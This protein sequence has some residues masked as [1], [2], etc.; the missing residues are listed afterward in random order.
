MLGWIA[1]AAALVAIVVA[2]VNL[3][4]IRKTD[5]FVASFHQNLAATLHSMQ[6]A[7]SSLALISPA[8]LAGASIPAQYTCDLAGQAG[9]VASV[10]P[11]SPPFTVSGVPSEAK[12]LAL[13]MDDPDVPKALRPTGVFDHWVLF[14]I[15]PTVTDIAEGES[16]GVAG[17]NGAG[18][19][20]YAGPCPPREYEPSEHRYFF[21]LFA[22]DTMLDLPAGATKAQLE[23]A[24]KGHV[25]QE[26]ELMGKY[27]RQ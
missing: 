4:F 20:S 13:V 11:K 5:T 17:A 6:T 16:I 27:K 9:A 18:E 1:G 19:A 22:L 7:S 26:A 21:K 14:N 24:M 10:S 8:F 12:S 23:E 3:D 15:P 25:L 2:G